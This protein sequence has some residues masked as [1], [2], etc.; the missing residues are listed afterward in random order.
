[1]MDT[2]N[3]MQILSNKASR[4]IMNHINYISMDPRKLNKCVKYI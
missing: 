1:M 2:Y 3:L 4:G